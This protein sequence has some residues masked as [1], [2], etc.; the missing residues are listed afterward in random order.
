MS[1]G[2]RA[3]VLTLIGDE[4]ELTTEHR[5]ADAPER[6]RVG[7]LIAETGIQ[8]GR[9]VGADLVAVMIGNGGQLERFDRADGEHGVH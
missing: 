6:V 7:R 5:G 4:A 2:V 3:T 9:L 8:R 1:E